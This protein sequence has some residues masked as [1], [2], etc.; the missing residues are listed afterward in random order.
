MHVY[1]H[2]HIYIYTYGCVH[3]YIYISIYL[4]IY[5]HTRTNIPPAK[6]TTQP[7]KHRV[8][9]T[10][11]LQTADSSPPNR[12]E[13][14][15]MGRKP[16]PPVNIP[17]PTKLGSKMGGEFT[18]PPKWDPKTVLITTAIWPWGISYGPILGWM[19]I[20]LPPIL[21]FT[22]GTGF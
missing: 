14:M 13:D 3:I 9:H 4:Y 6:K 12:G 7:K 10:Y 5:I 16:V 19:N 15:A 17:I 8:R 20:H 1:I 21:M 2:I 11:R 18:Y 22:R